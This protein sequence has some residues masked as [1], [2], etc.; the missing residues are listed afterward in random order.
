MQVQIKDKN[1]KYFFYVLLFLSVLA[2]INMSNTLSIS[3]K[4]ALNVLDNKSILTFLTMPLLKLFPGSDI[5]LR[6]PFIIFYTLSSIL[7]YLLTKDYF[8]YESDRF[9][10]IFLFMLLPGILSAAILV[11]TAIIV[12]FFTLLYLYYYKTHYKHNYY[13][14]LFCLLLDNSFAILYLALFFYGFEKKDNKL[15]V[16][17]LI[18]FTLSMSIYGFNSGGRP[19]GHFLDTFAIYASIFSP[20]LFLYFFYSQYRIAVKGTRSIYWYIPF[21]ALIFSLLFS[22]RQK[23]YIEDFA[24]FVIIAMPLM[25]KLFFHTYRVRLPIFRKMH[26]L[27][28]SSVLVILLLNYYLVFFNN[29][30]YLFLEKPKKHFIYNYSFVSNLALKL[31][32]NNINNISSSDKTLIKR[33]E[34]YGIKEGSSFRITN[35]KVSDSKYLHVFTYTYNDKKLITYYIK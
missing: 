20:L 16:V 34:F 15:I 31:K 18:L 17:S 2:L 11:N 8:K 13:I 25:V 1:Y 7:M 29:I 10:N 19:K 6:L 9:I 33:L 23:I 22:F 24:P 26:Y 30:V 5:F 21:V 35:N 28:A 14:L 4:E 27:I 3:Y 32:E 12:L